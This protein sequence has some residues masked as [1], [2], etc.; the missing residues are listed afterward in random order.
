MTIHKLTQILLRNDY[1]EIRS[2]GTGWV[3]KKIN[4][5][6]EIFISNN[7]MIGLLEIL[8]CAVH[9]PIPQFVEMAK[10]THLT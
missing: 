3:L 5:G 2:H 9:E 4:G 8:K 6:S 7:E 1:F 10:E